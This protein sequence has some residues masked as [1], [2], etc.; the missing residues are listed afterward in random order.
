[1]TW[2]PKD[3]VNHPS[4]LTREKQL[5]VKPKYIIHFEFEFLKYIHIFEIISNKWVIKDLGF[6]ITLLCFL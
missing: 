1:M 4:D 6:W 5:R 2:C 3:K